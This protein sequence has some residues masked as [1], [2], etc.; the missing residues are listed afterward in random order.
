MSFD[1]I[2]AKVGI[3]TC[4]IVLDACLRRHDGISDFLRICQGYLIRHRNWLSLSIIIT[5]IITS[6][7]RTHV[8]G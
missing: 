4:Q 8:L 5:S 3:H 1:V 6:K 2:P 7:L